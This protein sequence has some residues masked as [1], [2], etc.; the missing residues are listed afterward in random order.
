MQIKKKIISLEKLSVDIC[1]FANCYI[2]WPWTFV[3]YHV[4]VFAIFNLWESCFS[5]L[6]TVFSALKFFLKYCW[7]HSLHFHWGINFKG[8]TF[9]LD[10]FRP[11]THKMEELIMHNYFC[12]R[13]QKLFFKDY[14]R[15]LL[16]C[17]EKANTDLY[18]Y[19]KIHIY[20]IYI[21]S[22]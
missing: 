22:V 7:I 8:F 20:H 2:L 21:Y 13:W 4:S 5:Y 17:S 6:I 3:T 10:D 15:N 16:M 9:I 11:E 12:P 18:L 1:S 19:K 14:S